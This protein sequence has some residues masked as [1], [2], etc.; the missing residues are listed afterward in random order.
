MK[1]I[2]SFQVLK[3][4]KNNHKGFHNTTKTWWS[5]SNFKKYISEMRVEMFFIIVLC[6]PV[7]I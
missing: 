3:F 2:K 7:E 4:V 6:F 5:L 1:K